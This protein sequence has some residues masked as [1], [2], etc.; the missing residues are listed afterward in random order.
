M[1]STLCV[2]AANVE[3]RHHLLN[4]FRNDQGMRLAGWLEPTVPS[5]C[6]LCERALAAS[7]CCPSSDFTFARKR[8]GPWLALISSDRP[9]TLPRATIHSQLRARCVHS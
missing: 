9:M 1:G 7:G 3:Q 8:L 2:A 6:D 5:G 4:V